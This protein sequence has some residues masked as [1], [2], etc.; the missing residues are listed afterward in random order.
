M[1]DPSCDTAVLW[2]GTRITHPP[3]RGGLVE[4]VV[5]L[6]LEQPYTRGGFYRPADGDVIVDAGANI[7]LFSIWASRQSRRCRVIALEPFPENFAYLE[8]NLR[9]AGLGLE[10]VYPQRIALGPESRQRGG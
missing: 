7:G 1:V 8:A 2:D 5:E 4:I 6:W 10:R 3:G 9:A